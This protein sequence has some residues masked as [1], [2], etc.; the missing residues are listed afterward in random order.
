[1]RWEHFRHGADVGVRGVGASRDDAFEQAAIAMIAAIVDPTTVRCSTSIAIRCDAPDDELLL[2]D[3]LNAL[4]YEMAAL[5]MLFGRFDVTIRDHA[6]AA[7]AWGEPF[8]RTRHQ[9]SV[10]V[11]GATYSELRVAKRDDGTWVAQTVV[12][13]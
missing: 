4:I 2:V 13:V 6:L 11:K 3:W 5:D 8:D 12:D 10:E 7:M 1:M 9:T